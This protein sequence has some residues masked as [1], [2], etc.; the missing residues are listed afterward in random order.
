VAENNN[1][2]ALRMQWLSPAALT[3]FITLIGQF[4]LALWWARGESARLTAVSVQLDGFRNDVATLN[5]PLAQK[6]LRIESDLRT[7]G[8]LRQRIETIDAQGTRPLD[9][10][11]RTQQ[12]NSA[13]VERLAERLVAIDKRIG[14]VENRATLS[15]TPQMDALNNSIKRGDERAD[16]IVQAL[17]SLYNQVQELIRQEAEARGE[18]RGGGRR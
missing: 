7:I 14:D 3:L 6:V 9:N 11:I 1:N 13:A 12:R 4:A 5:T 16:R 10:V 8:E 15:L 17:D 18:R 2:H